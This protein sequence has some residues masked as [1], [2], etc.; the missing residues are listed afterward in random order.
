[1]HNMDDDLRNVIVYQKVQLTIND[2]F[3]KIVVFRVGIRV[4]KNTFPNNFPI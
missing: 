2:F 3:K 1:M 4:N